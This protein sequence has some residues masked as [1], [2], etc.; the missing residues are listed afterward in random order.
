MIT[1]NWFPD[2]R[3]SMEASNLLGVNIQ[4][5]ALNCNN[6]E[7]LIHTEEGEVH[8]LTISWE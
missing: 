1:G 5:T 6:E 8:L 4:M 7:E 2:R 3:M